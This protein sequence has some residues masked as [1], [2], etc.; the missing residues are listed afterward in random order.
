MQ[1]LILQFV[2]ASFTTVHVMGNG[3]LILFFH[4]GMEPVE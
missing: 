1:N 2:A 4:P 3:F